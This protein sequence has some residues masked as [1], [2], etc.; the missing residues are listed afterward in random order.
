MVLNCLKAIYA[1]KRSRGLARQ[2]RAMRVY[3]CPF[4]R[5]EKLKL[6][7]NCAMCT[8]WIREASRS[9][10]RKI[11]LIAK[12]NFSTQ[13]KRKKETQ[14]Q[15]KTSHQRARGARATYRTCD[16]LEPKGTTIAFSSRAIAGTKTKTPWGWDSLNLKNI[17]YLKIINQTNRVSKFNCLGRSVPTVSRF[18]NI[19]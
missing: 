1:R 4:P 10:D 8:Q 15:R 14:G 17:K 19:F 16:D 5:V 11:V 18:L 6:M 2:Y 7:T 13:R 12:S 9:C 3:V